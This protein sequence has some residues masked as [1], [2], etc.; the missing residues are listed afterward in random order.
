MADTATRR[1]LASRQSRWAARAVRWL[2]ATRITPNQ[3]SI[4]GMGAALVAGLGFWAAGTGAGR[5]L[6]LLLGAA[7]CQIRLLCNLFDGM[8][9]IEAGR[10]APDGGFWNEFPDRVSDGLILMGVALGLGLPGLGWAAV[11][12]AFLTAYVRELG[13]TCGGGADF[14]GPMAKQHRMAVITAAALLSLAE[15]LWDGRGQVL[16][17]A[18][19]LVT[20]GAAATALRRALRLVR[21]LRAA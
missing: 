10:A 19:W 3:I 12:F 8:V 9:A 21:K 5:W 11:S 16:S 20:L 2:A 6:F 4:A 17:A 1:P 15:P 18:L 14:A 13:V 7:G